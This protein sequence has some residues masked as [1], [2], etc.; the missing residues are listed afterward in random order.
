MIQV[1][2][3]EAGRGPLL[4]QVVAAAVVFHPNKPV[5]GVEDSKK[6]TEAKREILYDVIMREALGVGV[7]MA[8]VEEIA[9]IYSQT[10]KSMPLTKQI[11]NDAL[12]QKLPKSDPW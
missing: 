7:G 4:G 1:G 8:S 3:D 2:V 11:L 6:L 12:L 10:L 9:Q 5:M